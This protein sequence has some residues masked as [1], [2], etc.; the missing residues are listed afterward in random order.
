MCAAYAATTPIASHLAQASESPLSLY[1]TALSAFQAGDYANALAEGKMAG[2]GG[3]VEAQIMVGHILMNGLAGPAQKNEAVD[4]YM[5]AAGSGNDD[6]MV[7]LGE[8]ALGSYGGL[9]PSDAVKWLSRAA[10]KGRTDAMLALADIYVVGKGTAPNRTIAQDWLVKADNFGDAKAKRKL[11]DLYFDTKPTEALSWYEKAAA[12]G[13]N[14]AAYIAAIMYAENYDI[15]PDANKA[16]KLL[17]QAALAGL[18]AAQA[19]FGLVVYQG[20][21]TA[22]SM[23]E[24]AKWFKK[25]AENGDPEGQFLYAF[26]L[27]KGEGVKQSYEDAY[28]WLLRAEKAKPNNVA[29][30]DQSRSELKK[31]LEAN[32]DSAVLA[33]ARARAFAHKASTTTK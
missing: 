5:K 22:R 31:R 20:N 15:K 16:A 10:D 27:A 12:S 18:P 7:A 28:Y 17:K 6:A 1:E 33:R 24:A 29:D 21:G 2:L 32:V 13:D 4:W 19:D 8:L 9:S 23:D 26:T 30:Y 11:G 3:D 14:D 25:S